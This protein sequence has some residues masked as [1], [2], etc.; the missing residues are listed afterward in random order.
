[1]YGGRTF[2]FCGAGCKARFDADPAAFTRAH[3]EVAHVGHH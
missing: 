3:R 1:V 2:Y